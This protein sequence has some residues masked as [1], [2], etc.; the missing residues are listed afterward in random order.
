MLSRF[1]ETMDRFS[2]SAAIR[3][4]LEAADVIF[5]TENGE[6]PEARPRQRE[7]AHPH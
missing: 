1:S 3:T 5:V 6:G 4:A 2:D 7:R